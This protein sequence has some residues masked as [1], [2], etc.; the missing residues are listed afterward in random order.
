MTNQIALK[1]PIARLGG[2]SKLRS[3]IIPILPEHICYVEP[4][5]GAGWVFFGKQPSKVEVI[6]DLDGELINLFRVAKH[7][8]AELNRYINED[9]AIRHANR[10]YF[11]Q[12]RSIDKSYLTDVQK[13]ARYLY[14]NKVSFGS[15]GAHFGTSK[16]QPPRKVPT[17]EHIAQ[18]GERLKNA[19]V[20]SLNAADVI[21]K[22]DSEGTLHFVD[23]PYLDTCLE[24]SVDYEVTFGLEEHI[25]LRDTLRDIKGKFVLTVNAHPE[26]IKLYEGYY[27][28]HVQVPYSIANGK[29]KKFDE[30]IITNFKYER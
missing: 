11:A 20:E 1:P 5:F 22:Y 28:E 23:P 7:H 2:K 10:A 16:K 12:M 4:F 21:Q 15:K 26:I 30:V 19:V 24:F 3:R 29:P 18:I 27:I 13:A 25:K 9:Y 8:S 6:N 14:M 17:A